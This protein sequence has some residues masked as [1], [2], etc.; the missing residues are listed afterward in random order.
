[1]IPVFSHVECFI[2]AVCMHITAVFVVWNACVV[3]P[4]GPIGTTF[5]NTYNQEYSSLP[6]WVHCIYWGTLQT[7]LMQ[8]NVP[9]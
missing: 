2:P 8:D 1:M 6:K 7:T 5:G 9:Y 3:F 4:K